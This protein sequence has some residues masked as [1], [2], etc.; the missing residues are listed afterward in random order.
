MSTIL[1]TNLAIVSC[2]YYSLKGNPPL[3]TFFLALSCYLS[4]YPLVLVVPVSIMLKKHTRKKLPYIHAV[5]LSLFLLFLGG[6]LYL[7][8]VLT[9]SWEFLRETYGFT[10]LVEDLTPNIGLFWYY[11]VEIFVQFKDFFL[12][13]FQYHP[14][15]YIVPLTYRLN[16]HPL[17]LFWTLLAISST[18]KAYPALGDFALPL[19][20][21]PLFHKILHRLTYPIVVGVVFLVVAVLAPVIWH[22]WIYTGGG[23]ANFYYAI[24][25]VFTLAQVMLISDAASA[26]V[27]RDYLRKHNITLSADGTIQK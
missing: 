24:T 20:I 18:F 25:L 11:F 9:G 6:L 10:L 13:V 14:F 7:S 22:M 21:L 12:F 16:N 23:N 1:F 15:I 17:F 8:F 4:F 19:S 5:N 2:A 27:K 3:A 26:V